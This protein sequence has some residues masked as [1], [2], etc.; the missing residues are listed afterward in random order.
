MSSLTNHFYRFGEFTVDV[1]QRVLLRAGKPLPLTPKAFDTLLLLV[2][3]SG[4]IVEREELKKRLWPD[5]FV[6][7]ANIAFN[8]QQL[9]KTLNDDARNPRY[10]G[11]VARRGY[12]FIEDVEVV[13]TDGSSSQAAIGQEPREQPIGLTE[14]QFTPKDS[15]FAPSGIAAPA[16][17]ASSTSVRNV[18]IAL[19]AIAL[20][21]L[22]SAVAI[23]WRLSNR[24]TAVTEGNKPLDAKALPA[25]RLKL[26]QLTLTGQ[27]YHLAISPD[28]KYV[29]YEREVEKK[30]GIWIRQL[31]TNTNVEL[32]PPSE[33]IY[34]LAFANNSEYLYFVKGDPT[35]MY[36]VP[37]LGGVAAKIVDTPQG[38]FSLSTGD[39]QIAFIRETTNREG[40]REYSLFAAKADG[41][42]ER[43]LLTG[44]HPKGL[45]TPLWTPDGASIICSYGNS[46]GG[47]QEF[48]LI[49]VSVADGRKTEL[50]SG[51]FFRITKMAWLAHGSGLLLSARKNLGDNNQLWRLTYPGMELTQLT[52]GL[53]SYADLSL[54]ANADKGVAS[55]ETLSSDIWVGPS[56]DLKS[57]KKIT[58]AAGSFCWAPNGQL[59]YS[60]TASGNRDLWI[61]R[62]DGTEQKQL[63][64]DS[65]LDITPR[66][67]PDNRYIVFISNRTGAFQLWRM[68]LDGSNQIQLT[69]GGPKNHHTISADSKWVLY[70]TTDDWHLW[71]VSIDGGEPV[72]LAGFVATLPSLSPDQKTIVA[73]ARKGLR[74]EL[75]FLPFAGGPPS[76]R[77]GV[78]ITRSVGYRIKWTPDSKALIYMAEL[79]GPIAIVKQ[80][81]SGGPTEQLAIFDQDELFDFDYSV[82]GQFLAVT[83]GLWQHDVVL[84]S[85]LD[86]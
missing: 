86:Q 46:T 80:P 57:L 39:N 47:G 18:F 83:R 71:K 55:Q 32:V 25:S 63:T 22:A 49:E 20:L 45:D 73:V 6:E 21:V 76:K 40:Q 33:R 79:D 78:P 52:E 68:N 64:V 30:G 28:G 50:S 26:E 74:R 3:S 67:T 60:S 70:N 8:I 65:A 44:T 41:T 62:A 56:R 27:S 36:R 31:A 9:R 69:N 24:S 77:L 43:K 75:L 54:T 15:Q 85:D 53:T 84:I 61:M 72:K 34:G 42:G 23:T 5:T 59:V 82:D 38:N 19:A 37:L 58:Q 48:G 51:E 16:S 17:D 35:A 11:T 10:I 13:M 66:V 81:L 4:R 7:E 12:R 29:A 14:P 2:E 1:D